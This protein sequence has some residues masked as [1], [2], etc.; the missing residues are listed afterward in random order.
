[1]EAGVSGGAGVA[2]EAGAEAQ[3][4]RRRAARIGRRVFMGRVLL[5]VFEGAAVGRCGRVRASRPANQRINGHLP[6]TCG[7]GIPGPCTGTTLYV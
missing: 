2:V 3:A 7:P 1:M 4:V 6:Y 5:S